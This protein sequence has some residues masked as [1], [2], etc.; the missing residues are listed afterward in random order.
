MH[1]TNPTINLA[2]C[3]QLIFGHLRKRDVDPKDLAEFDHSAKSTFSLP[4]SKK[5]T[6]NLFRCDN[7]SVTPKVPW[8]THPLPG[9]FFLNDKKVWI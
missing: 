5:H 2:L 3:S 9:L 7:S 4:T 8:V 1:G 6:V